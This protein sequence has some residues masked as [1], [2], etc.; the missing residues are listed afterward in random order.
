MDQA[1]R[2]LQ[3]WGTLGVALLQ[4]WCLQEPRSSPSSVPDIS[5]VSGS[6]TL[7][8]LRPRWALLSR[9][10]GHLPARGLDLC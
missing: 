10:G 2:G 6:P 5:R 8:S 7:L 4:A 3:G 9:R 1:L